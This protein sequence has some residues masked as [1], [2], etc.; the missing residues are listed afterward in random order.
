MA[1]DQRQAA[2]PQILTHQRDQVGE[3][4]DV[5]LF[6][7]IL[8][9]ACRLVSPRPVECDTQGCKRQAMLASVCELRVKA[10]RAS[11]GDLVEI[12]GS[13]G[14]NALIGLGLDNLR[15][16]VGHET[17]TRGRRVAALIRAAALIGDKVD[18]DGW[19]TLDKP[20]DI[21]F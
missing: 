18:L 11:E 15:Q 4:D 21:G 17:L 16:T 7:L 19:T 6:L 3:R 13:H 5:E 12:L 10:E 2:L 14:S 9:L 8:V 1:G 20:L